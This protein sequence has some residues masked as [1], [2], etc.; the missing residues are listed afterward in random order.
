MMSEI[1]PWVEP[2]GVSTSQYRQWEQQAPPKSNFTFWCM[3]TKKLDED[4]YLKWA[5]EYYGLASLEQPFFQTHPDPV[6]WQTFSSQGQWNKTL[7]PV[8]KWEEVVFIACTEPPTEKLWNFPVR[9]LLAP[10]SDLKSAWQRLQ[11]LRVTTSSS[12][13]A[14]QEP[15]PNTT[16]TS[17]EEN[18]DADSNQVDL[19]PD[20]LDLEENTPIELEGLD[21]NLAKKFADKDNE[22]SPQWNFDIDM[23]TSLD[24][25]ASTS[26]QILEPHETDEDFLTS[27]T[28]TL[29]SF[30]QDDIPTVLI[31]AA[32]EKE[33]K[34][35]RAAKGVDEEENPSQTITEIPAPTEAST[36]EVTFKEGICKLSDS[37]SSITAAINENQMAS[38]IFKQAK[39]KFEKSMILLFEDNKLRPWKW[40]ESWSL[41][42]SK[43]LEPFD[44]TKACVFRVVLRTQLPYHGY[45][46]KNEI[47]ESFFAHWGH[48]DLPKHIT[49]SP[50]QYGSSLVGV[51]LCLCDEN[52]CNTQQ[53]LF[54]AERQAKQLS[55]AMQ[56]VY[57]VAS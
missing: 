5:R 47:N 4:Q 13:I 27:E 41:T 38:W 29:P 9:Y 17:G 35:K 54:F 49:I 50:I 39:S 56:R 36:A 2:L 30:D 57:L 45:V 51:L 14:L 21:L 52:N 10:A 46:T 25:N 28:N 40:D 26:Q 16:V 23:D 11:Q 22:N 15:T 48:S 37:P 44:I 55:E 8:G 19:F 1:K 7:I 3:E 18:S 31:E 43:G 34:A 20:L 32:K 12:N 53:H 42:D 24:T 33:K 6:L